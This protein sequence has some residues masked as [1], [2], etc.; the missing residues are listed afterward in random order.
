MEEKI[1]KS[2]VEILTDEFCY[3]GVSKGKFYK[4]ISPIYLVLE[5]H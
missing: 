1:L 2:A 4:S 5:I 3:H